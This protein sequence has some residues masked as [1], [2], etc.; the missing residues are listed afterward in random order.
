MI[1]TPRVYQ[2]DPDRS[3]AIEKVIAFADQLLWPFR[4]LPVAGYHFPFPAAG[5]ISRSASG[6]YDYVPVFWQAVL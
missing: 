5:Y 6:N 2:R 1:C 3:S 4:P